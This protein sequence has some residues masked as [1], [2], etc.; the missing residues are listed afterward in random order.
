[1]RIPVF[2]F[3]AKIRVLESLRSMPWERSGHGMI[4]TAYLKHEE[5]K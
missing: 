2:A 5:L 4:R 1:M 3:T